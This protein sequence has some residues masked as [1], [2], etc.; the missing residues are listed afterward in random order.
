MRPPIHSVKHY[1]QF[2]IDQIATGVLQSIVLVQAV[3]STV[4]NLATEVPEGAVV[5]AV[6]VELWLQNTSN[7]GE[8]IV[9]I[10]KD[11]RNNLGPT[12]AQSSSLF[13]YVNKKNILFVHQGLTSNDGVSGPVNI[14]RGWIKIPKSKQRMG[15]ADTIVMTISNVSSNDLDRCGFAVYK[16]YT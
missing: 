16:E 6:Y 9:T 1:V 12:F 4:A 14:I 8:A 7:L 5:K 13:T 15:L 2:P 3:E 11:V 10:S